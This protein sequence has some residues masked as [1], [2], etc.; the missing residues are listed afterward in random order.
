MQDGPK[1]LIIGL[2]LI[3]GPQLPITKAPDRSTATTFYTRESQ[4]NRYRCKNP[5]VIAL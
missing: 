4:D 5:R 1:R 2:S 3:I